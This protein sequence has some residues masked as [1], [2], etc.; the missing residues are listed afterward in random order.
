MLS[1]KIKSNERITLIEKDEII[2]T[3][4]GTAKVLNT[5]FSNIIQDLDIQQYNVDDPI[6]ENINDPLLK[7][8]VRY[9]NHPSIVAIRKFCN[10]KSHFSFKN[11]QKEEILK[12]LNNLNINKATQNTDIPTNIIKENFDIFGDFIFSN[13]NCC[14][15][16]SSYPSLLKR[17]DIT[18]VH[19]KDS[20]TRKI[21]TDQLVYCQT[22]PRCMKGL[23]LN[24]C[25]NSLKVLFSLNINVDLGRVFSAQHCLVSMLKK[26]KS[27]TDNKKLFG[28]LLTDLSKAFDCLSHELLIAKLNAYGFNMSALRFVHSYLKNRMQRTKINSEYS[29]WEEILFGVPQGSILG[30][31][32]FNIFLCDLFLIMENIDIASY[33]DDNTP[34]TTENPMEKVIQKLE[35]AAET[36]FQWF[37][38]NQMKANPD[39][40]HFL[41]NS[42]SEVS[43]AIETQK[44][45]NSK[46][47]KLLGITLDSKLSF[48]SHIHDICQKA[49]KKLNAISRITPNMNFA[50]RRLLVNAFFNSQF[51][52]CQLVWMCHN[53]TNNNK[54]NRLHE[55][56]LRLIDNDKKSSFKDLLEKGRSVSI[57]HRNLRTLAVELFKVLKGL[58]PVIFAETFA[59]ITHTLLC[60]EPKRSI[61]D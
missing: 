42:N 26:W 22:S 44:I 39:K 37:S 31:L 46:F 25:Q 7:A 5:F 41:C 53:R 45:K 3:E 59:G 11:V 23:C 40:C 52:Y 20:K 1:K 51:N 33:G 61:M 4:K 8:I 15:N 38:D 32:L 48:N 49:G 58:S 55:R 29:S 19:K 60:L 43:L 27:A 13:F 9:R 18:P 50:K 54:I 2:E 47:E 30:P 17:A 6:C 12:E 10:S 28:A 24:K 35:N 36:L 34:Y 57:H 21:I 16:T 14:I 56:C